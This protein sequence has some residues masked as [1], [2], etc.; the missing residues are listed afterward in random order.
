M[1]LLGI[2]INPDESEGSSMQNMGKYQAL[3]DYTER[4]LATSIKLEKH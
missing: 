2:A 3:R 4:K 1:L